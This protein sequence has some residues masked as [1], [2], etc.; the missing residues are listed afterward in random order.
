MTK[1]YEPDNVQRKVNKIIGNKIRLT[2]AN[3]VVFICIS[4]LHIL[5]IVIL[6]LFVVLG[7]LKLIVW[8]LDIYILNKEIKG[9][10]TDAEI[11]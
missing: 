5:N 9:V 4:I 2:L 6:I 3:F 7:I 10:R 11:L 8:L 1:T